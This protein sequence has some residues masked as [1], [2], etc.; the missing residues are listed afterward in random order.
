VAA[1]TLH[2][3]RDAIKIFSINDISADDAL[4][5]LTGFEEAV[6]AVGNNQLSAVIN[7]NDWILKVGGH[8]TIVERRAVKRL[9]G[10]MS[11]I[12]YIVGR[13]TCNKQPARPDVVFSPGDELRDGPFFGLI[14]AK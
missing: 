12:F 1:L 4:T 11:V 13:K 9:I 8:G 7:D 3:P 6:E 14:E 5:K 10:L 2:L